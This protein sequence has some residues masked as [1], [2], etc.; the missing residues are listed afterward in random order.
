MEGLRDKV[1]VIT[2]AAGALG[3]AVVAETGLGLQHRVPC[4]LPE[5][6]GL[7]AMPLPQQ[8]FRDRR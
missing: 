1:V 7:V 2:G 5:C 3:Q 4:R 6:Y 8:A